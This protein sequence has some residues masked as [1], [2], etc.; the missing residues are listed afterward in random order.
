MKKKKQVMIHQVSVITP[1]EKKITTGDDSSS[2]CG[3]PQIGRHRHDDPSTGY[4]YQYIV[5]TS[6]FV[7]LYYVLLIICTNDIKPL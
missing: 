3:V 5:Y 7:P 2:I 4:L 6:L 1:N